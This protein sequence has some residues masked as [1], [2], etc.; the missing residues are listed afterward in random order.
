M[1]TLAISRGR[2]W[3]EAL[4]LLRALG[5]SPDEAALQTRQL[6]IPTADPQV[7][8][9]PVRAQDAPTFVAC[10]AA[11]MGIAGRDVLAER[12]MSEIICPLDLQIAACRLV[13]AAAADFTFATDGRPLLVATKYPNLARAH[14]AKSGVAADIIKLHGAM[15]LAP[16]VGVADV[17]VDL[18]ASG[19]TLHENG[20]VEK[21][22]ILQV[23]AMLIVNRIAERRNVAVRDLQQRLAALV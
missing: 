16:Q 5:L 13:V 19:R 4:P 10:G 8:L 17:I 2:I 12:R 20:L 23:S 9:L 21:E 14:F 7:R 1:L 18:S 6:I 22:T 11:Q 15:E 3:D